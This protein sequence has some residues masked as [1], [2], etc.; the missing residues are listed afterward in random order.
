MTTVIINSYNEKENLFKRALTSVLQAQPTQVIVS[1]VK[2]DRCI[3]WVEPGVEVVV[4]DKPGIFSQIEAAAKLVTGK[5]VCYCSSNDVMLNY[6]LKTES[7]ILEKTGKKVCYSAF[8][9]QHQGRQAVRR[10][11]D[12]D[13]KSHLKG[14]YVS[15][16]AM[17]ETE[18]FKK[19]L[20]FRFG[21]QGYW[22]LFLRIY[23]GEGDVFTYNP[24]PTWIYD[25]TGD[26][27]HQR[28]KRSPEMVQRNLQEKEMVIKARA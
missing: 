12:Y 25:I 10:F 8:F 18:I 28:R 15:D 22:D 21:N 19:Y 26:S 16:C 3:G 2:G 6:K 1:T 9:V 14:S 4:S 11:R 27:R 7:G 23:E 17:I 24:H 5:Y 13:Y 20:P